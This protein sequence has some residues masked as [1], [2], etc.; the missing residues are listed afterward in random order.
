M[1]GTT[2][3]KYLHLLVLA[4]MWLA[5][6]NLAPSAALAQLSYVARFELE[7]PQYMAGEPIFCKFVLRNTGNRVLAF[8][9]RSPS[10]V[11][12]HDAEQEPDFRVTD[13]RGQRLPDPAP[14]PCG[15]TQGTV[16]YGFVALPPGQTQSERWLLNQWARFHGP[17]SFRVRAERR[18]ALFET[19]PKTGKFAERP[20]AFASALDELDF[21]LEA[22]TPARLRA[23]FAPYL[24]QIQDAKE[25]D[26]AE[27]VMVVTTLPQPFLLAPLVAM[28]KP[29]KPQRWDRREA[30]TGMARLGTPPAWQ[31]I[32]K[33]ARG[34]APESG[35]ANSRD[36]SLRSYAVLLL[37]EKADPAFLPVLLGMLDRS[38]EPV[39]GDV[40]HALGFFSGTGAS[41]ALFDHLHSPQV[42]DRMNSIL[43]LRNLG[44]RETVPALLA[45]LRDAEPQVRGVANFALESVTGH[46]EGSA[47]S[48]E[49]ASRLA[50]RW[51]DWW[52]EHGGNFS[53]ARPTACHD[54]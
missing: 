4:V 20:A 23:A 44:T 10:R 7:K 31:E 16:V 53:P 17:G 36:D 38:T 5:L 40:L 47:T 1:R 30:L 48:P 33:V 25:R 51:H 29:A 26:P 19:D 49:E 34:A 35:S 46:K 45:M 2:R 18:L 50:D 27:A 39:R 21:K 11:L 54:W 24:A 42:A 15:G 22:S 52:R 13:A 6:T 8:R 37:A 3:Q 32:V 9:Y 43:G 14:Q 41:Q 12:I 28:T